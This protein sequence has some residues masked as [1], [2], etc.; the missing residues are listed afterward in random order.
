[1]LPPPAPV[2]LAE[3]Q[4]A[5]RRGLA[6]AALLRPLRAQ[7]AARGA[8]VYLHVASAEALDAQLAALQDKAAQCPDIAQR[9]AQFPLWGVPFVVKDNIDIEGAPTTAACPAITY[10][11]GRH[12]QVVRRLI[13]AG[14][15]WLAKAN[16]DQFATGL[17]GTRSPHGA[18]ASTWS[19]EH[20]SGGSSSGS[21]VAVALGDVPFALGTDTAGSGRVPAGFNHIVGLK[22]TPGRVSTSGV[23]PACRSLD[24]PSIFALTVDDAATVLS[25]VEGPDEADIYSHFQPGPANW[26]QTLRV[27][28]PAHL[29]PGVHPDVAAAFAAATAALRMQGHTVVKIDLAPLQAV[30]ALLYD[31]PWVA[32]RQLVARELLARNPDALDPAVRQVINRATEFSAADAFAAQ[33]RLRELMHP[34]NAVW[35]QA[36]TLMVPTAPMHPTFAQVAADPVG[37]NAALGAFTN[38]VNLLGWC[39]LALPASVSKAGLPQG[40]T[41]IAPGGHDAALARFGSTWQADAAQPLG[42]TGRAH[43]AVPGAAHTG[44]LPAAA[45]TLPIVA[46]GAHMSG[47][48]LN[49]QLIDLGATL[50][51]ATHT[52]P[53]YRLYALPDT[54]P[55]KPGLLRVADNGSAIAVEVWALPTHQ[56]GAFLAQIPA[57]LGLGTVLLQDGSSAHGFLC[58]AAALASA[59]DVT[60]F[61]GWRAYLASL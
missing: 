15:V 17:V 60:H 21:A 39:A 61:G 24:C 19:A 52:A 8:P 14:A 25:V 49:H 48:P 11:A 45:A 26:P 40:V 3:W 6:A 5:Y 41:F 37:V 56:V 33:Y 1:M 38:F 43:A 2:T 28:V 20:I 58:E 57:P 44:S 46:V 13:D 18:P 12:A 47:L 31:G 54:Q 10:T 34:A 35:Q 9:Q 4:A 30:A 22:P 23:L 55:A 27:A 16:M 29:P 7:L 32:E 53:A 36:H 42:A 50:L 59:G 51:R